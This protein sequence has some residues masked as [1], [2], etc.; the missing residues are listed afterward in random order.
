A[1]FA[2][3]ATEN[4]ND[5]GSKTSGGKY[6]NIQKGQ[7]VPTFDQYIFNNPVGKLGVVESDFGFHVLKVDKINE[8]EGI[9][10]ATIAK[11]IEPSTKTEDLLYSQ[12]TKFLES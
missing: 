8:K 5:S 11:K 3:L 4:T 7:M 9:Q 6:P 10:L 2:A 12:A 1:D